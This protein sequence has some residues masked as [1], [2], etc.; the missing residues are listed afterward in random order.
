[1]LMKINSL[2]QPDQVNSL[3]NKT[4]L[5]WWKGGRVEGSSLGKAERAPGWILI[6]SQGYLQFYW[7]ESN[8]L[9]NYCQG[10][11][12]CSDS[13]TNSGNKGSQRDGQSED[14]N[15]TTSKQTVSLKDW[16]PQGPLT[17]SSSVMHLTWIER[18]P[19]QMK[20]TDSL[21]EGKK[22]W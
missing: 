16:G 3:L 14:K 8:V 22:L 7:R 20:T 12:C 5:L 15:I 18:D 9:A 11:G 6:I 10:F 19:E 2:K 1:M 13:V 21:K 17:V 4:L